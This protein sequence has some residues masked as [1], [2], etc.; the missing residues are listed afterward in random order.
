MYFFTTGVHGPGWVGLRDFFDQTQK[1][2]LVE[3]VAQPN[4]KLFTTVFELGCQ[5]FF[6]FY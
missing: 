1:F 5:F 6:K 3:L 2:G 4:P